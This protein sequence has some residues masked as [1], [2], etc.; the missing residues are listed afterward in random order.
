MPPKRCSTS[1]AGS[2]DKLIFF[3]LNDWPIDHSFANRSAGSI[4]QARKSSITIEAGSRSQLSSSFEPPDR[5]STQSRFYNLNPYE[6][7]IQVFWWVQHD[8]ASGCM[9]NVEFHIPLAFIC[10]KWI[11]CLYQC[12]SWCHCSQTSILELK[13]FGLRKGQSFF[14]VPG[15]GDSHFFAGH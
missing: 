4:G 12:R 8:L 1:E 14:S 15:G 9:S 6:N 11:K 7:R 10:R 2:I 13:D 5:A 3:A